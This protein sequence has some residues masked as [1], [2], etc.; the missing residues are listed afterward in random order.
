MHCLITAGPTYEPLD[1]VRRLTNFSTGKLGCLLANFLV[2][3]GHE[4]R[5]LLGQGAT[6]RGE[7][8]AQSIETFT[9]TRD[10][11]ERMKKQAGKPTQAVFHAAAVSDFAFGKVFMRSPQGA[12]VECEAGKLSTRQGSLLAELVPASKLI[13]ELRGWFPAAYL[14]GWKYDVDGDRSSMIA[15]ARQQIAEN[16]TDACVANGPA[17]GLG[18]GLVTPAIE[19]AHYSDPR[20][21]FRALEQLAQAGPGLS[22]PR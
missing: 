11:A 15:Q 19:P 13:S 12:L 21:L 1:E 14:V 8:K 5:L 22:V 2:E 17:Y 3:H 4:V 10:L 18:F 7:Q 9:T 20:E 16:R 6:Y